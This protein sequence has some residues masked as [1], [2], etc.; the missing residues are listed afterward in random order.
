MAKARAASDDD[1]REVT[2]SALAGIA[3][4]DV[5]GSQLRHVFLAS[6]GLFPFP[7]DV[8][9]ELGADAL[10]LAGATRS[11]PVS[12][13][14]VRRRHLPEREY[15][16]NTA[17]QK[18]RVAIQLMVATYGGIE[19]DYYDAAGWWRVQDLA[20]FSFDALVIMIRVA[21]ERSGRSL[22]V[23]CQEIASARGVDI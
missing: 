4:G 1:R 23:V 15:R 14:D 3:A 18:S 20:L 8:L 12:L 19:P 6:D 5:S 16:G 22:A 2:K 9:T 7:A 13:V 17:H 21:A 10:G 11:T